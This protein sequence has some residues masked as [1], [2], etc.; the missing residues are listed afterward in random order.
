M[1]SEM[2]SDFIER[3]KQRLQQP[4]PGEGAQYRMAPT[5][6]PRMTS[7][8]IA[9]QQ[10]RLGG[11]LIL[12]Y[13]KENEWFTVFT[14]RRKYEGVHSGQ[15]SFPGGKIDDADEDII[16]TALREAEEE[17]GVPKAAVE[18]IG[19]LTELY[20]PPSNFLVHPVVAHLHGDKK[21]TAQERE[22]QEIV[23]IPLSFFLSSNSIKQTEIHLQQGV[24]TKVPA[25]V[26]G[27]YI[28]WG[29][30]AIVLS[31]LKEILEEAGL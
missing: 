8:E 29:A 25:F 26:F 7:D 2:Q 6:R 21:F 24:T 28:I 30:T 13:E 31:E 14:Q 16:Q 19:R 9:Q 1:H 4:L 10:P 17:I 23:E 18:V 27:E 22:V 15:M 3:V 12:L 5:Y 20:I 11:V